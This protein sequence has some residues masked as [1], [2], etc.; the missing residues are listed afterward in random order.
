MQNAIL[1]GRYIDLPFG[2]W[3]VEF[4]CGHGTARLSVSRAESREFARDG[5]PQVSTSVPGARSHAMD[6]FETASLSN[7]F[8]ADHKKYFTLPEA[9]RS[10]TLVRRI[11]T[12]AVAV[13]QRLCALHSACKTYELQNDAVQAEE[14]REEYARTTDRLTEL[15]EELEKI[16]CDVRDYRLGIV[17]FP[18]LLKGREVCLCWQLGED[19]VLH[20]HELSD[21]YGARRPVKGEFD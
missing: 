11:V 21:D 5:C 4:R 20:W 12:D 18:A 9:N 16:G 17:G 3:Y 1:A 8:A 19:L 14:T 7:V 6:A 2:V 10:L 15:Q 13:Y